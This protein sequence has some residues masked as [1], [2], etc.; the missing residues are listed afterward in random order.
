MKKAVVFLAV[1]IA[2]P[3]VLA[4][5]SGSEGTQAKA[6]NQT[7]NQTNPG[8]KLIEPKQLISR[9]EAAGLLKEAAKEGKKTEQS[10]SGRRSCITLP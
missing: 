5:C 3:T 7:S 4:A 8:T 1:L 6:T 9:D 10:A 2:L